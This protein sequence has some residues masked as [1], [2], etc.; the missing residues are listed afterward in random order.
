MYERSV[1]QGSQ[2]AKSCARKL[3][4]LPGFKYGEDRPASMSSHDA[5]NALPGLAVVGI[6]VFGNTLHLDEDTE[7]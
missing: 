3:T 6:V 4:Y 1:S 5:P 2:T 7:Y